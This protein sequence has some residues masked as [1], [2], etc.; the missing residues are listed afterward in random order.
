[1]CRLP[2]CQFTSETTWL[3][4]FGSFLLGIWVI[5]G[6]LDSLLNGV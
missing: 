6:E 4:P 2:Q 1:M 5:L 3:A